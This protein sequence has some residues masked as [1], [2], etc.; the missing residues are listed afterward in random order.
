[1][2]AADG[3]VHDGAGCDPPRPLQLQRGHL[4]GEGRQRALQAPA[5]QPQTGLLQGGRA[6][7]RLLVDVGPLRR[8]RVAQGQGEARRFERRRRVR[9]SGHRTSQ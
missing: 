5:L 3:P 9:K 4:R 6:V 1:M 2:G 7:P 8:A